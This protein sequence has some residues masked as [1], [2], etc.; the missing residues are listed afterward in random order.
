MT[1][2]QI[3]ESLVSIPSPSGHEGAIAD[4]ITSLLEASGFAVKRSNN[5]LWF[6][7][8]GG[9]PRLL[10]NSHLDTVPP[11]AG[12]DSEPFHPTWQDER[13]YGLGSNDAKGCVA[14][15]ICAALQLAEAPPSDGTAVFAFTAE[16]ETGGEG[17]ATI[18]KDLGPLD[19]ALVGEPTNLQACGAQR[20]MLLLRCVAHGRSAHVAHSNLADNAIHRAA[21]DITKLAAMSFPGH[22]LLGA[23]KAQVTQLAGGLTRNQVPDSC[24]FFVDLRTTPNQDHQALAQDLAS[25]LESEV[26]IHS[27]RYLPKATGA[28]QPILK[29]ALKANGNKGPVGSHTTSDWAFLGDIPTV[30]IGPGDTHRSHQPNEY[31]TRSELEAGVDCY[32]K[33]IHAYFEE[34]ASARQDNPEACHA[35]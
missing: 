20:G 30:K 9:L 6:E 35:Q 11:S 29:A 3:L 18:L 13:L 31:L 26:I 5:N 7:V 34:V 4:C 2:A 12:W 15:M 1:P 17:I 22:P 16:E 21:R 19:A 32:L 14:A 27:A 24:E 8:G 28:E 25:Q 33:L 23:A 10:V